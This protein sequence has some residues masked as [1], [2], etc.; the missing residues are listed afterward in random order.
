MRGHYKHGA[1]NGISRL[2]GSLFR[3]SNGNVA[4]SNQ[5]RQWK[6][7]CEM[8]WQCREEIWV[9]IGGREYGTLQSQTYWRRLQN[10]LR[11]EAWWRSMKISDVWKKGNKIKSLESLMDSRWRQPRGC[12]SW[13]NVAGRHFPAN[14]DY[15]AFPSNASFL[16]QY[17][18]GRQ[19]CTMTVLQIYDANGNERIGLTR[20]RDHTFLQYSNVFWDELLWLVWHRPLMYM[21]LKNVSLI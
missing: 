11:S 20:M 4:P 1:P 13:L 19:S 18:F 7:L 21:I 15:R 17:D 10:R 2:H 16:F 12:R 8:N 14:E 6:R 5:K 3:T 9:L